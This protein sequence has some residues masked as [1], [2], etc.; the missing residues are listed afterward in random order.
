[1]KINCYSWFNGPESF[2]GEWSGQAN[3]EKDHV[4]KNILQPYK[5]DGTVNKNSSKHKELSFQC[6]KSKELTQ[7]D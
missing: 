4:E 6:G 2:I 5:R 1:L 7:K 3:R